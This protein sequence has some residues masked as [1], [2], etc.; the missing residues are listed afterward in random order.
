MSRIVI[1]PVT[2][3]EGHLKI[4]VEIENGVVTDAW[5]SGTLFRGIETILQGREPEEAWLLTQRLCGVCTYIH[6]VA[7][8]RSVEDALNVT[9]PENARLIRNLLTGGLYVHDHPVHFYHLS[10]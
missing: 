7:S 2:R 8:V 9:V 1:D 5:S 3:I 6:G 10:A 4:E